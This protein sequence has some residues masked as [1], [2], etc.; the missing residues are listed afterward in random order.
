MSRRTSPTGAFGTD[1]AATRGSQYA[2]R[3]SIL[4]PA[5]PPLERSEFTQSLIDI[6]AVFLAAL[7]VSITGVG[8]AASLFIV[9]FV[10]L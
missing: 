4:L 2:P 10:R 1:P 6:A 3:D 7:V 9:L 8:F 5:D